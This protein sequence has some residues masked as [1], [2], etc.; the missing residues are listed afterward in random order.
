MQTCDTNDT[1][2]FRFYLR[3]STKIIYARFH[4]FSLKFHIPVSKL[5]NRK[6]CF[7]LQIARC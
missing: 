1:T 2:P 3:N 7:D 6:N 4:D 5:Y